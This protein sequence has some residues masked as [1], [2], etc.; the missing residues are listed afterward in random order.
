M[1]LLSLIGGFYPVYGS[2]Y[3]KQVDWDYPGKINRR[4]NGI[5]Y[6]FGPIV[7]ICLAVAFWYLQTLVPAGIWLGAINIGYS[8]NLWLAIFNLLPIKGP[9]GFAW[10]GA[11]IFDWNKPI[12]IGLLCVSIIIIVLHSI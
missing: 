3:L 5:I 8:L 6:M 4:T 10:D 7:H 12:W 1:L 9:G 2:T 11:K